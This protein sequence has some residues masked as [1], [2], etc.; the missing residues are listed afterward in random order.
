MPQTSV[1][2]ALYALQMQMVALPS[3][4]SQSDEACLQHAQD[5]QF[6]GPVAYAQAECPHLTACALLRADGQIV[7][8]CMALADHFAHLLVSFELF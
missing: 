4:L 2:H 8:H 7:L 3:A 5:W 1:L 6:V